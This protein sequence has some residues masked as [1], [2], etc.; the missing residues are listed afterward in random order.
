[1][2]LLPQFSTLV[3]YIGQYIFNTKYNKKKNH[4]WRY[5]IA[6]LDFAWVQ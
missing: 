1:M 3:L 4:F 2:F 6:L 5:V